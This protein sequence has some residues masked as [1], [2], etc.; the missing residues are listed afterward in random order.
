MRQLA[1]CAGFLAAMLVVRAVTLG[2]RA[3][4]SASLLLM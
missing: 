2:V 4:M 1:A 3:A